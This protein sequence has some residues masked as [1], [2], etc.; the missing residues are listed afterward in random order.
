MKS[1]KELLEEAR[2]IASAD[3]KKHGG[4]KTKT[5]SMSDSTDDERVGSGHTVTDTL[6]CT[7]THY[8]DFYQ[9]SKHGFQSRKCDV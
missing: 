3:V 4:R 5:V 7:K 1:S 8:M 6:D 9:I 2:A